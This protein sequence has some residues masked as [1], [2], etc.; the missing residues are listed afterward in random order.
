VKQGDG[1]RQQRATKKHLK[2]LQGRQSADGAEIERLF[3]V[4]ARNAGERS[5]IKYGL[6]VAKADGVW[7]ALLGDAEEVIYGINELCR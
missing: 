4:T 6:E 1:C 2:R 5:G 7:S 3:I